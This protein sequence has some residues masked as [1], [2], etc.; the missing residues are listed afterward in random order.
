[1][2]MMLTQ[3]T[4]ASVRGMVVGWISVVLWGSGRG[5]GWG[6]R[7]RF[8]QGWRVGILRRIIRLSE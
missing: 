8:R 7:W 4:I 2:L 1:M 3:Q 5:M 6:S